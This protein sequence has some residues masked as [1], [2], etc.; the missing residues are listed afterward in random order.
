M[1]LTNTKYKRPIKGT[2]YY[3]HVIHA[4]RGLGLAIGREAGTKTIY[5]FYLDLA[6]R[7]FR[8]PGR[9]TSAAHL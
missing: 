9:K 6:Q 8:M 7:Q 2:E 1:S 5:I 4:S 3:G